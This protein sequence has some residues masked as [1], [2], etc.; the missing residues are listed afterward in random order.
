M[1]TNLSP[2]SSV[3]MNSAIRHVME[4]AQKKE[5]EETEIK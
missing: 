1:T 3:A 5:E 4:E 2:S